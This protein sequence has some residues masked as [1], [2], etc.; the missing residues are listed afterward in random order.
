MDFLQS[1]WG[2]ALMWVLAIAVIIVL[3]EVNYRY[4]FKYVLDFLFSIVFL[5]II[6]VPLIIIA[7]V[8]KIKNGK[9]LNKEVFAG[10]GGKPIAITHLCVKNESGEFISPFCAFLYKSKIVNATMLFDVIAQRLSIIGPKPIKISDSVF[11]SDE[12]YERFTSRP[13]IITPLFAYGKEGITYEES[14]DLDVRYV[15]SR[16]LFRDLKLFAKGCVSM[17][18]DDRINV[19]GETANTTYAKTLLSR[20]EINDSDYDAA[21]EQEEKLLLDEKKARDFKK[22]KFKNL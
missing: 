19:F 16:Q 3:I 15:K 2:I 5:A 11:V 8:L 14:F 6:S 13:G 4:F 21:L 22:E 18:R 10:V 20:G 1:P 12:H 9:A 17:L 7:T